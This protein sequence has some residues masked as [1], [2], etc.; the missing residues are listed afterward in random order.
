MNILGRR[1]TAFLAVALLVLGVSTAGCAA[2]LRPISIAL[3][4]VGVIGDDPFTR[5]AADNISGVLAGEGGEVEGDEPGLYGGTRG[6]RHCDKQRLVRYLARNPAKARAWA[7]VFA[8]SPARI[9][10]HVRA[11]T[12]VVLRRDILVKNHGYKNGKTTV[13][14][15]LLEAGTAVLVD[16]SGNPVVK[17]DCGNPLIRP[18]TDID[19]EESKY[20]GK[21]W[22]GFSKKKVTIVK[23][24]DEQK[25]VR[26]VGLAPSTGRTTGEA[27]D[28]PVGSDGDVDK[29]VEEE[30]VTPTE[31][32]TSTSCPDP[33][34]SP[35]PSEV[36][37]PTSCPEASTSPVPSDLPSDSP[38]PSS[39]LSGAA[40]PVSSPAPVTETAA[41]AS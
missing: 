1:F 15:A 20:R 13:F 34:T 6:A 19:L 30:T 11:L 12:P 17:C 14:H 41:P 2:A 29:V 33:A 18:D 39:T 9:R 8:I 4:A 38:S 37:S 16:R 21:K 7:D 26:L 28:R 23:S 27:I 40:D 3:L 36:S 22:K 10:Q 32:A 5:S 31:T 25:A 24:G 35:P